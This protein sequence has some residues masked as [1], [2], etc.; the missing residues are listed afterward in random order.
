MIELDVNGWLYIISIVASFANLIVFVFL[1][2]VQI[3]ERKILFERIEALEKGTNKQPAKTWQSIF[4][5]E[6]TRNQENG[7]IKVC[8]YCQSRLDTFLRHFNSN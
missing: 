8:Q 1:R 6:C 7:E 4:A 3:K 5:C 2:N